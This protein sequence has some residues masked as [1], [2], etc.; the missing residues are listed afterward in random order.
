[1]IVQLTNPEGRQMKPLTD[2]SLDMELND[3]D[4]DFAL[5]ISRSKYDEQMTYDSRIFVHGTEYGG[6]IGELDTSTSEDSITWFW[7]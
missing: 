6:I 1:M 3:G 5:T 7:F 2:A 4:R